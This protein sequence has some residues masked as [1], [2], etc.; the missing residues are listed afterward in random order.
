MK[1]IYVA[2]LKS[3]ADEGRIPAEK[4]AEA[5]ARYGINADKVASWKA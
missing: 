1:V 5:I 2:A 4:V 3:L